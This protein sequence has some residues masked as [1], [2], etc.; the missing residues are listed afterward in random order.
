MGNLDLLCSGEFSSIKY[1]CSKI[2]IEVPNFS[3]SEYVK[4]FPVQIV[5]SNLTQMYPVYCLF[6]SVNTTVSANYVEEGVISCAA[7]NISWLEGSITLLST[8]RKM[9][10]SNTVSLVNSEMSTPSTTHQHPLESKE[11]T[12]ET[13]NPLAET[14]FY[15]SLVNVTKS[16]AINLIYL[17]CLEQ[18]VELRVVNLT[19]SLVHG[20]QVLVITAQLSEHSSK[21]STEVLLAMKSHIP[22]LIKVSQGKPQVEG[23][24]KQNNWVPYISGVIGFLCALVIWKR[25]STPQPFNRT[26]YLSGSMVIIIAFVLHSC[27]YMFL[28]S[29]SIAFSKT[30]S[31]ILYLVCSILEK[32]TLARYN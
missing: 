8:D 29:E 7:R 16:S 18:G 15:I 19:D 21:T 20:N 5:S 2:T 25:V 30:A 12:L 14:E 6:V 17:F 24:I 11:T 22:Q 23:S 27:S 3:L 10:I 26:D 31:S 4:G 28:T 13:T 1:N 32:V 9:I